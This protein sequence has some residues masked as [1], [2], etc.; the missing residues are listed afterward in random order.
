MATYERR[1]VVTT[2]V[3]YVIP[4]LWPTGATWTELMKAIRAAHNELHEMDP[5]RYPVGRDVPDDAIWVRAADDD[6]IV[7]WEREDKS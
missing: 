4:A 7:S 3:E 5:K 6:V 1:E 2:R